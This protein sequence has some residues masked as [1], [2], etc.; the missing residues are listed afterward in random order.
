M[1]KVLQSMSNN[2]KTFYFERFAKVYDPKKIKLDFLLL[3][4]DEPTLS[5]DVGQYGCN[6]HW[7]PFDSAKRKTHYFKALIQ[8]I[9]VLKKLK[10]DILHVHLF[11]DAIPLLIAAKIVGIKY[12]VISKLDVGFHINNNPSLIKLDKLNNRLSDHLITVSKDCYDLVKNI[13]GADE[14][15]M[16]L[17]YQGFPFDEITGTDTELQNQL[18]EQFQVN[19]RIVFLTVARFIYL[20]GYDFLIDAYVSLKAKGI[21]F[22]AIFVGYGEQQEHYEKL[23]KEKGLE[24]EVI[25]SSAIDRNKLN[26]L[27]K[28]SNYFI[29]PA[30]VEPFGFVI[31]EAIINGVPALCTNV[32]SAPEAIIHKETGFLAKTKSSESL[33][34]GIEYLLENS[35]E[36]MIAKGKKHVEEIF[37]MDKMWNG[38]QKIYDNLMN[39]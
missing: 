1:I 8:G 32:G 30:V 5:E 38:H 14:S 12:K 33:L 13:E 3:C 6:V 28:I 36:E 34:E 20:K 24:D 39:Q 29:H 11:D 2:P 15:K 19:N 7:I 17:V 23:I 22:R 16:T 31:P 4:K 27:Y 21:K 26:N 9:K 18:K 25:L 37:T 10:P 35:N